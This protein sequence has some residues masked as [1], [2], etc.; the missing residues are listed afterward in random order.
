MA[1]AAQMLAMANS[2]STAT[3]TCVHHWTVQPPGGETSWGTCKKCGRRRRFSNRFDGRDRSNN[4]DIF[5]DSGAWRPDRRLTSIPSHAI[6]AREESRQA[7]LV[8]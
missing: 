7:E 8:R 3:R 1:F 2:S 5:V 4:S 6:E